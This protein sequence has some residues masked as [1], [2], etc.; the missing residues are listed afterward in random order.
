VAKLETISLEAIKIPEVR[1]S[2][3]LDEEQKA[4]LASTV[5]ELG[6]IQ[7]IVVR[8]L[9]AGQYELVA[10]KSRLAELKK[11]GITAYAVKVIGANEKLALIMNIVENVARGSYDYLSVARAIRKL[12]EMGS[13]DEEL[14]RV[15]P[16]K[17]RWITFIEDLQDMPGDVQEG[18]TT[19]VLTPTHV[20]LALNLPTPEEVHSG[21]RTAMTHKWNTTTFYTFVQNRVEQI[22]RAR[23]KAKSEGIPLEIPAANP[24]QL[25]QYRQCLACGYQKKVEEVTTLMICQGCIELVKYVTAQC[26]TPEKSMNEV[27]EALRVYHGLREKTTGP[28]PGPIT[29]DARE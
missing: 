11:L 25:V 7:D 28:G 26:G 2:S 29:D 9:G 22:S 5:K 4:L 13:T 20:Q 15:F 17:S 1:V 24:A 19:K 10:G 18:I 14:E 3:I 16:W 27:F 23:E 12:R 8:D 21:L 6:T